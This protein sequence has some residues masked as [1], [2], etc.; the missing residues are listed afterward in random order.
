MLV[1]AVEG[2]ERFIGPSNALRAKVS[3][4]AHG[5]IIIDPWQA[6][7]DRVKWRVMD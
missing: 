1:V 4:R 2:A 7:V 5:P 3:F 6:R